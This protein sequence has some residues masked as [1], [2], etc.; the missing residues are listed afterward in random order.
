MTWA[1]KLRPHLCASAAIL[2]RKAPGNR[3]VRPT[4]PDW[5]ILAEANARVITKKVP[6]W[7]S[8]GKAKANS[9]I[10]RWPRNGRG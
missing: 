8:R 6:N 5:R 9:T 2:A 3:M 7:C 4:C 1:S 10:P